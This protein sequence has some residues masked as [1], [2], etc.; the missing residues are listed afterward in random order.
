MELLHFICSIY[1]R[2]VKKDKDKVQMVVGKRQFGNRRPPGVKG[3][4]KVVDSRA[5]KDKPKQDYTNKGK[6]GRKGGMTKGKGKDRAKGKGQS[7]GKG[8]K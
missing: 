7:K 3:R 5:K 1:K 6:K 8:R 2:A 4:Y